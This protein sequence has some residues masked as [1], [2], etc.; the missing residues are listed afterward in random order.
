MWRKVDSLRTCKLPL[1]K[2]CT[3][4][5]RSALTFRS[6]FKEWSS[7][8]SRP[9]VQ[10]IE[11][12]TQH[13]PGRHALGRD[14]PQ[15]PL[16]GHGESKTEYLLQLLLKRIGGA[17][18]NGVK[19]SQPVNGEKVPLKPAQERAYLAWKAALEESPELAKM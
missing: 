5:V 3:A 4:K 9:P 12:E 6:P 19:P 7:S 13:L 8:P 10:E 17:V 11:S 14:R 16:N 18:P 2:S 15:V 1:C